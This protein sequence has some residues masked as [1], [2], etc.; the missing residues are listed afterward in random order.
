MARAA[1]DETPVYNFRIVNRAGRPRRGPTL[2]RGEPLRGPRKAA[3][4]AGGPQAHPKRASRSPEPPAGAAGRGG[5]GESPTAT[6]TPDRGTAS[7]A[8]ARRAVQRPGGQRH[9]ERAARPAS[10]PGRE[11]AGPEAAKRAGQG[12]PG[13][14]RTGHS[15]AKQRK[16]DRTGSPHRRGCRSKA[17][18]ASAVAA[19]K[20]VSAKRPA[21]KSRGEARRPGAGCGRYAADRPREPAAGAPRRSG[22]AGQAEQ[23]RGAGPQGR[24]RS[25]QKKP[26]NTLP[27]WRAYRL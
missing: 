25:A 13:E 22:R 23:T 3:R 15:E 8:P 27:G 7:R 4:S 1:A 17:P 10:P 12:G 11:P 21:R 24:T 6:E 26:G 5:A 16:G 20:R 19:R 18:G 14:P 9:P 2:P